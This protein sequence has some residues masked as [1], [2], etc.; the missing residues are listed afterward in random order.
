M[1]TA[2]LETVIGLLDLKHFLNLTD[3]ELLQKPGFDQLT[4]HARHIPVSHLRQDV[5]HYKEDRHNT[6][7]EL[8]S[9]TNL[10]L[11]FKASFTLWPGSNLH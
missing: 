10:I 2:N 5:P 7:C 11:R 6:H 4:H 3:G 9:M 8:C 1:P